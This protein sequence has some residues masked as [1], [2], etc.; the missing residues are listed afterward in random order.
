MKIFAIA[1]LATLAFLVLLAFA[2]GVPTTIEL[3][4]TPQAFPFKTTDEDMTAA[5]WKVTGIYV[6]GCNDGITYVEIRALNTAQTIGWYIFYANNE[7]LAAGRYAVEPDGASRLNL[8]VYG[9]ITGKDIVI[10]SEEPFN[11]DTH[12]GPCDWFSQ[13]EA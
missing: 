12:H 8:I 2:F 10:I 4:R 1:F 13:E 3:G 9:V 7:K 5:G 6:D 11:R